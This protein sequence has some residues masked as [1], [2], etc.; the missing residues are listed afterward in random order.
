MAGACRGSS[1]KY[2]RKLESGVG[3]ARPDSAVLAALVADVNAQRGTHARRSGGTAPPLRPR[4][5]QCPSLAEP[6][7]PCGRSSLEL[8]PAFSGH[9]LSRR[10]TCGGLERIVPEDCG[11]RTFFREHPRHLCL[12]R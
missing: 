8:L 12:H 4:G 3:L 5:H 10:T 6:A 2:L 9:L 1:K 7:E 11:T